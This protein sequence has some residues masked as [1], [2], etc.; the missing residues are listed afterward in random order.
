MEVICCN[1]SSQAQNYYEINSNKYC[2]LNCY[3]EHREKLDVRS[4]DSGTTGTSKKRSPTKS[5]RVVRKGT[6]KAKKRK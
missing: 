4:K 6:G 1:C 2:Q 5:R 3:Y